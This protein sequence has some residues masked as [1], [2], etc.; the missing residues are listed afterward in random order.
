MEGLDWEFGLEFGMLVY[1]SGIYWN[2]R[3]NLSSILQPCLGVRIFTKIQIS[4]SNHV[5]SLKSF[6]IISNQITLTPPL[7]LRENC[8]SPPCVILKPVE[9]V[10]L[11][12]FDYW[13]DSKILAEF[14]R[15]S[16]W[17]R[18]KNERYSRIPCIAPDEDGGSDDGDLR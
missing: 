11:H 5:K 10:E 1:W 15:F 16:R 2:A 8:E 12:S 18:S 14:S 4:M 13:G 3:S 7:E 17:C 9:L 6:Q